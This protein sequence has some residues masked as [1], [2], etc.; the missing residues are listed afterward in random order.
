MKIFGY[1]IKIRKTK[2]K[3][4][5]YFQGA[6]TNRLTADWLTG[7]IG[8]DEVLRWQLKTLRNRSRDLARNNDYMKNF[9][10]KCKV[11]IIGPQGIVLQNK[12]RFVSS[13]RLYDE[14]NYA[15]ESAW[16]KWTRKGNCTVC[17]SLRFTDFLALVL[18]TVIKDGEAFIIKH[19]GFK[20]DFKFALQVFEGHAV[21]ETLNRELSNDNKIKLGIEFDAYQAPVAYYFVNNDKLQPYVRVPAEDV[22]HVYMKESPSQVRGIPWAHT[23][24]IRLRMLGAYEEASLVAARIGAAKMGFII[25]P[26]GYEYT[27]ESEIE[28]NIIKEV[29]PGVLETLPAGAT[30]EKFDPG[31]PS[32]E[33]QMFQKAMLRGIAAGLGCNYNT[34][35]GDLE[36]VNFSSLRAGT[37]EER[38]I[39][40]YLQ[41]WFIE[42]VLYDIFN[43][44]LKMALLTQQ[45]PLDPGLYDRIN[46]PKFYTRTWDWVDPLK[47][48]EAKLA[49]LRAGLTSRTRILAEKGIDFEELLEE[50]KEEKQLMQEKGIYIDPELLRMHELEFITLEEGGNNNGNSNK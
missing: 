2:S 19:K 31:Q 16:Q 5:R 32:G 28:G 3:N 23:A 4:Y 29:E 18:E 36:S 7:S 8:I 11:N 50:L 21:D 17:R 39:W 34:L 33:F 15:I 35:A 38:D 46:A 40:K 6:A 27:G 49:E 13:G 42:N 45:V 41:S 47:D 9:I 20:N 37:L 25:M 10:R 43:D 12:A 44:W 1:E 22:I 26:P 30:F 24:L 48:V 14:A